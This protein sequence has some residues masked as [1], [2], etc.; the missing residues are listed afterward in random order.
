MKTNPCLDLPGPRGLTNW[1][2]MLNHLSM[3]ADQEAIDDMLTYGVGYF[4]VDE[5]GK[6]E[7]I[8]RDKVIKND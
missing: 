1:D 3:S 7:H 4:K 2:K 5:N 6:L 8:S